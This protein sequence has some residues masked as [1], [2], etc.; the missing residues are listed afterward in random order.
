MDCWCCCNTQQEGKLLPL[1]CKTSTPCCGNLIFLEEPR[2]MWCAWTAGC[3]FTAP[4]SASGTQ[5]VEAF[6]RQWDAE[7]SAGGA[8]PPLDGFF[9]RMQALSQKWCPDIPTQMHDCSS[10]DAP[11]PLSV[12][13]IHALG[14]SAVQGYWQNKHLQNFSVHSSLR[15]DRWW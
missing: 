12:P 10:D 9:D 4:A 13:K 6:P 2:L 14:R 3:T 15:W 5:C 1:I 8:P 7:F 11:V